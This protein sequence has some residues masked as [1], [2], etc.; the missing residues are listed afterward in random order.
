MS[1]DKAY[2]VMETML[3]RC[4]LRQFVFSRV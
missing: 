1:N 4:L 2:I 3:C